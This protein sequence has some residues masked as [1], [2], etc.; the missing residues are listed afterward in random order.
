WDLYPAADSQAPCLVFIHGG[1]WQRN[2]REVFAMV[3]EGLN[4]HGWSMALP[5][6][7]LAPDAS[8][9]RIVGEIRMAMDRLPAARP[10]HGL[11]GPI[12]VSGWS[13]GA[14]LSA[15][16]LDHPAVRAGLAISGVYELGPIR[17]TKLNEALKLTQEEVETL[18]PLRR[19]VV[20]KPLAIAYG[21]A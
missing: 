10:G 18:S 11:S 17:D 7:T 16:V 15:M 13:A 19:P 12:I 2:S 4:A 5:S 1:Y 3:A 9:T 8:L 14:H 6:H 20:M 21:S